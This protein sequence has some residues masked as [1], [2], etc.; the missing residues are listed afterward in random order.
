[1]K[2]V[3]ITGASGF[4]GSHL[5]DQSLKLGWETIAVLRKTS[6]REW[7]PSENVHVELLDL[8]DPV[9]LR[10]QMDELTGKY[11]RIN[12]VIHS[13]GVTHAKRR[14]AF[15]R[16]NAETTRNLAET[17]AAQQ[18]LPD[19][20]VLISSLAAMGPGDPSTFQPLQA[21]VRPQPV[22][23]YGRSK[24]MAEQYLESFGAF[25]VT[26]VRPTA[27]YGPRDRDFLQFFRMIAGG[28]EPTLGWHRQ[29]ISMI[30]VEDLAASVLHLAEKGRNRIY[31]ASDGQ[32][33]D[34]KVLGAIIR[35]ALGRK[36]FR[37]NFPLAPLKAAVGINEYMQR[38]FG[39]MPFLNLDKL[40]EIS[41]ANWLCDSRELWED[42]G[43]NPTY[44][45]EE[46][47]IQ[48]AE[49]YRKMGWL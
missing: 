19:R 39:R 34:K 14:E 7:I 11:G 27:V 49:W 21:G 46:G 32:T 36:I 26:I 24:L 41:S 28:F 25:P 12:Y 2:R 20:F 40:R 38:P 4:I 23:A 47:L 9:A 17:L 13:A 8:E 29:M 16:A 43:Q 30:H 48:T 3:L 15:V 33:Y 45:L 42:S 1:M 37:I 5:V 18:Q 44:L 10:L 31:L 35:K 22:S 6:S